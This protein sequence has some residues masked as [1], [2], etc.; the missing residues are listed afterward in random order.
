MQD[1]FLKEVVS[2]VAGKQ[3]EKIVDII[4][5]TK[6]VSEFIIAKKLDLTVNQ[7]RN[8][9]YKLTDYGLV[10]SIRK[11]DRKKGWFTYFWK[12]ELLKSLEFYQDLLLKRKEQMNNQIKS[13]ETKVFYVCEKCN[14]E[15]S[16]ETAL[17][18]NFTCDECG[19]IFVLKD[20]SQVVKEMKKEVEK[21]DRDLDLV[22]V[23]VAAERQKIGKKRVRE[24]VKAKKDAAKKREEKRLATKKA[25]AKELKTS[26]KALKKG[27]SVKP[28]NAKKTTKK[29]VKNLSK[30]ISKKTV[31]A[32]SKTK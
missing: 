32:K 23:D 10:S 29:S 24:S 14:V 15:Y 30:K 2:F 12:I 7:T 21:I 1:K 9:L 26:E 13:R 6:Y 19:S 5:N 16:E 17:L 25:K 18:H 11:K 27:K 22:A 20:N 8:I 4:D 3:S 31:K 28:S